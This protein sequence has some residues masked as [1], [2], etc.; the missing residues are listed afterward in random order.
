MTA[1]TPPFSGVPEGPRSGLDTPSTPEPLA[2]P[3]L[4]ESLYQTHCQAV[5]RRA[6]RMFALLMAVQWAFGIAAAAIISPRT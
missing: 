4:A 2:P 5:F 3:T 1:N 6:D